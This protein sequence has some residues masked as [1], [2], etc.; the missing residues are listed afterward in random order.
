MNP[1]DIPLPRLREDLQVMRGGTSYS[2]E[3]VWIVLDPLRNRFFRVTYE[4]F[5]LLSVWNRSP[6]VGSLNKTLDARFGRQTDAEEVG[7]VLR[8]LEANFFLVQ[9]TTG[10]WRGLYEAS[11][12][13]H[14]WFMQ[15]IHNYLFFK[16]P[17]V[18]PEKFIRATWPYVAPIFSRGFLLFVTIIGLAGLYLVSRQWEE[19]VGTFSYVFSFEGAA[20]SLVSIVLI[21]SLHE[22]GHAYVAHRHGCRVPTMGVAFMVMM[23]LLYTDVTEAWKLRSRRQRMLIDSAGVITELCVAAI[24]LFFWVFLPDG[25]LR[26]AVFV[27]SAT[28]WILS[29]LVNTNP[30]MRFDGYYMLADLLGIE[31]LQPRAFRHMR[32]RLREFLFGLGNPAPEPF[33]PRLD[34]IVTIYAVC[35]VIYRISLYLGIALLV[36]HFTIKLVGV[37]LFAVEIGFFMIRP[38][39]NEVREWWGMRQAILASRR[40]YVTLAVVIALTALAAMPL[41]TRVSAPALILPEAFVRLFP[42]EAGHIQAINVRRGDLVREGDVLFVISAPALAQERTLAE[43][44]IDLAEQRI[45]RIGADA[46]DLAARGVIAT[47]LSSLIAKRDGLQQ[48][49]QK[50]V[51]RAPF[52]GRI[53]D[54]N[55]EIA[56]GQWVSRKEQLAFLSSDSGA[57]VR[58][59]VSGNDRARIEPGATGWFIPDDLTQPR[60]KVLL[61]TVAIAGARELE[62]PQLTSQFG[63]PIAVHQTDSRRLAPTSA[64]YAVTAR[65][66]DLE[67]GPDQ[68]WRGV[69]ILDGQAESLLA[70]AW[71]QV[72]KVLVREAG[73]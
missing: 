24:A 51:V 49:E 65:A 30:F 53:A 7:M 25:P 73:A 52:N 1:S 18:R 13:H 63:G 43:K 34:A 19:F 41:S 68:T 47:Q 35:T 22:L 5:Q 61:E 69:L 56:V 54:L 11:R 23:P 70:R 72:L 33:P 59:Y 71:R 3:P 58:G 10:S 16:I 39:W 38:V 57:I 67:R 60:T 44:E 12:R 4:M 40:T 28:G 62:I 6:T 46:E 50:L 17:L 20:V 66:T 27:L 9:P 45:A 37:M 64:E 55:A 42:Q 32:W 48:R 14:S 36:Y 8:L 2:G 21:K 31:N 26:S 29:L 15:L